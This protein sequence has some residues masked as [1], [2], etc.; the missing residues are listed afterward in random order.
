MLCLFCVFHCSFF[1][2]GFVFLLF[3]ICYV[4]LNAFVIFVFPFFCVLLE[5]VLFLCFRD[6]GQ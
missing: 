3:C 6:G 1:V 2:F 5:F 4:V